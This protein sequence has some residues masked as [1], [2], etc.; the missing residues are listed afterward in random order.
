VSRSSAARALLPG[1]HA[2]VYQV[3]TEI[4]DANRASSGACCCA[5]TPAAA[6]SSRTRGHGFIWNASS[7]RCPPRGNAE[8]YAK[9]V[10]ECGPAPCGDPGG[11]RLE[12]EAYEGARASEL[13]HFAESKYYD[14]DRRSDSGEALHIKDVLNET[15]QRIDAM[16]A[17]RITACRP[18][19][20][21]WTT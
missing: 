9:I 8:H 13:M 10:R 18:A 12:A 20:T 21:T 15:F 16:G 1:P 11:E 2:D 4:F 14:L 3:L 17:G 19:S 5:R 7:H 6:E